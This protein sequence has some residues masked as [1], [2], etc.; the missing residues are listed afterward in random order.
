MNM[1]QVAAELDRVEAAAMQV[2]HQRRVVEP[3]DVRHHLLRRQPRRDQR[4]D[5]HRHDAEAHVSLRMSVQAQ[6]EAPLAAS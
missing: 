5:L 4:A 2:A 6:L 1:H 3:G